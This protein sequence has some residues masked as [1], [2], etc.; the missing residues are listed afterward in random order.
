MRTWMELRRRGWIE[1]RA[2]MGGAL[3]LTDA[4]R[5]ALEEALRQK[6]AHS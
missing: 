1:T 6:E 2:S 3:W 4:G 5:S